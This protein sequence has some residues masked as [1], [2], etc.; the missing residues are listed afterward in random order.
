MKDPLIFVCDCNF[1]PAENTPI[2]FIASTFFENQCSK[3]Y[4]KSKNKKQNKAK[5]TS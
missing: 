1:I 5:K 4:L 2:F 3:R